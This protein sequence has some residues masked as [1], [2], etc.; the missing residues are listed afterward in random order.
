MT[1]SEAGA[2]D[3]LTKP[4][5]PS[6]LQAHVKALLARSAK[7]RVNP[8]TSPGRIGSLPDRRVGCAR[9]A[10]SHHCGFQPGRGPAPKPSTPIP[11]WPNSAPEQ[12]TLA[13][14]LNLPKTSG[15]AEL[16][17]L[18][19]AGQ[20]TRNA[21]K[22]RLLLHHSGLDILAASPSPKMAQRSRASNTSEVLLNRLR[23][24]AK[25][26]VIDLGSGLTPLTQKLA[27]AFN[28]LLVIVEPFE[29]S[30]RHSRALIDDLTELGVEKT[31]I[32]AAVNY[33]LR[34]EA[35]LS[36]P[37][38]QE[39]LKYAIEVTFTPAPELMLQAIRMQTA[40]LPGTA[41]KPDQPAIH[42]PGTE[43]RNPRAPLRHVLMPA[44]SGPTLALIEYAAELL[45]KARH[46]V[47]LTGAGLS[48]PSGI[49][50][51]RSEGTGLWARDEPLEVASPAAPSAP[52]PSSSS[53][54]FRPLASQI[55]N[56][57]PSPGTWHWPSGKRK[58]AFRPS[59]PRTLTCSTRK[60]ARGASSKCTAHCE[61][62]PARNVTASR[63]TENYLPA[64]IEH[65]TILRCPH[66]G[67]V[68]KP[69]VIL[70]GEQLPQKA[71]Y[72]AQREAAQ[73]RPDDGGRLSLEVLPVAGLPMQ[74]IDRGAHLIIINNSITY[75]NVRADV[76][77]R[78]DA[79][80]ILPAIS[81]R[82]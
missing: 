4:T 13:Y 72:E 57:R 45:A 50:D 6:E 55:F 58:A 66:C 61:R 18:P 30:L 36:V 11:S 44:F 40:R 3:Y 2:D 53:T 15:L 47:V 41:R 67:A 32:H 68:L 63:D 51:F 37:Q 46:A 23:Y 8:P 81:E 22:E 77:L 1:G 80:H 16:L 28:E 64:F 20:I 29:H 12:G 26:V 17:N 79:A 24:M 27:T 82:L 65:G 21:V 39:R 7:S 49:P 69:D 10:G 9:R 5:H 43:N 70:F 73:L 35:Q 33:R 71:W 54:G 74:A 38:V 60:P 75:P 56:A 62:S 25:Y 52:R 78:E 76:V 59:S 14:D 42:Q 19:Q 34:S 48:T 31:R